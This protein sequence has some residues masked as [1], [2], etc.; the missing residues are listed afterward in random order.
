MFCCCLK[1]Y[2]SDFCQTNYLLEKHRP[3]RKWKSHNYRGSRQRLIA[4]HAVSCFRPIILLMA[5][6]HRLKFSINSSNEK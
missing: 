4:K 6:V 1:I 5:Q 2:F 3:T